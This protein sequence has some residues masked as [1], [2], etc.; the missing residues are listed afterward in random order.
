[1]RIQHRPSEWA[2]ATA[3]GRVPEAPLGPVLP[4]SHWVME[5]LGEGQPCRARAAR[6]AGAQS[7][8]YLPTGTASSDY[9]IKKQDPGADP[10][11]RG[12]G[13]LPLGSLA[14]IGL[15]GRE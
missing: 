4:F 5:R 2:S 1:M 13:A 9:V 12:H 14:G 11:R 3:V 15:K 8:G 6:T 10:P 7:N